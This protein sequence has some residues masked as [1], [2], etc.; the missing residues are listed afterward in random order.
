M[1]LLFQ[2]LIALAI[3]LLLA[4]AWLLHVGKRANGANWGNWLANRIDG[5]NRLFMHGFHR[6]PPSRIDLPDSG[7][8]IVVANH[9][10]GLD[11]FI[12]LASCSRPLHFLIAEE[13]YNR[14]GMRWLFDLSGCIPVEKSTRPERALRAA[15]RELNEGRVIALFPFGRMHLDSDPPIKIKGGVA[16][17][18][19]RSGATIYPARIEGTAV[20]KKVT[21]AVFKRG[22]PKLFPLDPI[23]IEEN[24]TPREMLH[25]LSEALSTPIEEKT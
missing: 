20:R 8:A 11:A 24:E 3:V 22:H 7:P 19:G 1:S 2:M 10:S 18:A 17:L 5:I 12:L 14:P 15:L 16:V 13:Q 9:I 21:P 23:R 4:I 25:R 6:L